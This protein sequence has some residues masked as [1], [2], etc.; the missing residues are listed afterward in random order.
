MFNE[1]CNPND[2]THNA[3]NIHDFKFDHPQSLVQQYVSSKNRIVH[4]LLLDTFLHMDDDS[5]HTLR[6]N[7]IRFKS[8][9]ASY[10]ALTYLQAIQTIPNKLL[11]IAVRH[12]LGLPLL[13]SRVA[14]YRCFCDK[15]NDGLHLKHC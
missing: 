8:L 2:P 7:L 9:T 5:K 4:Q 15:P 6:R 3:L 14:N 10:G 1:V 11:I 13:S 12:T